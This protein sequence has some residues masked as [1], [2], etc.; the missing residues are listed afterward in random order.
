MY[1]IILVSIMS[2]GNSIRLCR[3]QRGMKQKEL[4]EKASITT[5]YLSQIETDQRDPTLSMLKK[6]SMGLGVPLVILL[7]LSGDLD[8]IQALD[9][10]LAEKISL[11]I[12]SIINKREEPQGTLL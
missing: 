11:T 5:S 2:I 3:N 6:I 4:A 12:Y 8:E 10:E 9:K 1:H 7:F